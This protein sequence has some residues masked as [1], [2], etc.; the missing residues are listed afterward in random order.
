MGVPAFFRWLSK[1]YPSII[2]YCYE[3]KVPL[4]LLFILLQFFY[5]VHATGGVDIDI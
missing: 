1:K 3:E 5:T 2:A 4:L